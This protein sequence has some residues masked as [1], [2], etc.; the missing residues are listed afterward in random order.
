MDTPYGEL[1][2]GTGG[3]GTLLDPQVPMATAFDIGRSLQNGIQ[4]IKRNF[5]VFLVGGFLKACTEGG[6]GNGGGN[7]SLSPEDAES[8]KRLF[9][10]GG[11]GGS[12]G[13]QN[14]LWP[15]LPVPWAQDGFPSDF[16]PEM[17]AG[18]GLGFLVALAAV[19]LVVVVLVVLFQ[20]WFLPGWIRMHARV[21]QSGTAEFGDLFG[22]GDVFLTSLG[23][24]LLSGLIG[25]VGVV[26]A[27]APFAGMFFVE[28]AGMLVVGVLGGVWALAV[29]VALIYLRLCLTFVHHSIALEGLGVMAAIDRSFTL[30]QG[31]RGW[32]LLYM[33]VMSIITYIA[34]VMGFLLCCVGILLTAPLRLGIRDYGF[35]EGFL[36]LTRTPDEVAGYACQTWD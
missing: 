18:L 33:A 5:W 19:V 2:G 36:R 12:G 10:G 25:L 8:L 16:D 23:W 13:A 6:G 28:P 30:T 3:P 1:P 14:G 17:L 7:N 26:V 35:T 29:I 11:G 24:V 21:A 9:Q 15:S 22:A 32:L 20:S 27:L 4:A 34:G 31:G